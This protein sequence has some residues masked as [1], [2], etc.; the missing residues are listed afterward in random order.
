MNERAFGS[1]CGL[2]VTPAS[3]GAMRFP[4][5]LG[6]AVALVRHAIDSGMRYI[7]TSRGYGESEWILREALKDGYRSKVILSTKCA[8][9]VMKV[10]PSDDGSA[11]CTRRR[12]EESIKRLGVDY[13]DFYQAWSVNAR[14]DYDQIVQKGGMLDGMLSAKKD[15]LVRHIGFTTHDSVENLLTYINEA[16]WCEVI[17]FTYN[18]LG[19]TYAPAI[20]AAHA[21]GIGTIVMNPVGG[22][23]LAEHS[24]LLLKLAHNV[25]AVSVADLAVRYVLSNPN[26]DTI[27][28]GMTKTA[29][30]DDTVASADRPGFAPD[31]MALIEKTLD[32]V[33]GAQKAFCTACRY[34]M[35]CPQGI[36]IPAVMGWLFD[37]RHWG[38][39]DL[40]KRRYK[41]HQGPKADACINCGKCEPKCTQKLRI[42]E[43][44]ACAARTLADP[45]P[46]AR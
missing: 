22:G 18:M 39:A 36:D 2:K 30:V 1:R 35:P 5:D 17:L 6:D 8:P 43:E 34:C 9:W 20:E 46:D 16:D 15:G 23:K 11:D 31:A 27:L 13:L 37:E 3:I 21:K 38:F 24:P 12:I 7:D 44:M 4:R 28:C 32:A 25:G 26:V 10:Q 42:A 45:P 29:D 19:R 40:A 14:A 41:N 33:M